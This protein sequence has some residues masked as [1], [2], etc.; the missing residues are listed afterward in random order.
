LLL[1]AC[2]QPLFA[3]PNPLRFVP[4][5]PCRV[6]NTLNPAGLF[7]GP[8]IT[9]GTSRD[10]IIPNG[11]CGVPSTAQAY[12]LNVAVVV[13]T[14]GHLGYL[15]L[16]PT[17]Q[18]R[19]VT[20]T[21][22]SIDG[23]VKS[24]AA[25]VP[26]GTGE[27][28][29]VFASDTTNV[30][31]DIGGYFVPATDPTAL[32]F[33]PVTPCR[34]ADTR[35]AT[36]PLGGPALVGGQT[37]S[38]PI[39]SSTCGIPPTAQAYSL[40]FAAIPGGPPLGY[41]TAWPTG[42][43]RPS[44]SSLNDPTGTVVANAAIVK[45]GT[46]GSINV[47]ASDATNLAIDM[48]GYFAAMSTG[49]L[50]LYTVPPCRIVDT[51]Q[52]AGSPPIT[53]LNVNT[54]ASA[55]GIPTTAQAEIL[56]ATVVP[57]SS[58]GY[59]TLWPQGQ[60]RPLVSTLNALDAAIT[61]NMAIVPTSNGSISVFA[62][63]P[64]HLISDISGYFAVSTGTSTYSISGR[65]TSSGTGLSGVTVA[66][67]GSQTA[68]FTTDGSGSYSFTSVAGGGNYTV[69]PS[70]TGTRF[71]PVSAAIGNLNAN[72][73][74]PDFAALL[75]PTVTTREYIRLGGRTIAIENH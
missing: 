19:P 57:P 64:T 69:T 49:G 4:I 70:K 18:T 26:A 29:S 34:I 55:C 67:S 44:I 2:C 30:I 66:L 21:L 32:A 35:T 11:A 20:S 47:F 71:T 60:N 74:V 51:R 16:W 59:L 14:G 23:R 5:A 73:F 24:N 22:S 39:Q 62:S 43:A 65:V 72:W 58:L 38:F 28:I 33:F 27:S 45:A 48:N 46:G 1:F 56:S 13:P 50:S 25:I 63:D 31:L 3:Q 61:S 42:L 75:A 52:P 36:A 8:T 9:G 15:T 40:N 17:G 12:S 53:S 41:L 7:G 6:V 10:F 68:S 54:S 37:R